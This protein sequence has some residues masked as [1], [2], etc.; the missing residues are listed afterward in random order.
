MVD[1]EELG[2]P[3]RVIRRKSMAK[4]SVENV[5][6]VLAHYLDVDIK[7]YNVHLN[8]PGGRLLTAPAGIAMACAIYSSLTGI[9]VD[10]TVAMTGELSV[11][12]WSGL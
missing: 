12:G 8:F 5:L 6:T 3:Q 1:E 9:P 11:R 4:G 2:S 7:D 10:N